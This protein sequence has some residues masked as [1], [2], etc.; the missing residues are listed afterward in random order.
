MLKTDP[1]WCAGCGVIAGPFVER[2]PFRGPGQ[3]PTAK[4][5]VCGTCYL[6]GWRLVDEPIERRAWKGAQPLPAGQ[7][8][9][10]ESA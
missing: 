10:R 6:N 1:A 3:K 8:F 5:R 9:E 2:R 4:V 7:L